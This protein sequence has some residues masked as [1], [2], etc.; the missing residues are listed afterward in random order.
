MA[1][2]VKE[3]PPSPGIEFVKHTV[4]ANTQPAFSSPCQAMVWIGVQPSAHV[5]QFGLDGLL[6]VDWKLVKNPAKRV[7]P[8]LK[9]GAHPGYG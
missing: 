5:I 4:I 1:D 3:E 8:N 7:R 9:G 2:V 6:N